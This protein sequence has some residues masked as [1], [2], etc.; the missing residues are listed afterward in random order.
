MPPVKQGRILDEF[1]RRGM[2]G[3]ASGRVA[4]GQGVVEMARSGS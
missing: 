1:E 4:S 3:I 2:S